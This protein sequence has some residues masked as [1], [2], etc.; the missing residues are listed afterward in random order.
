[1][2]CEVS[3]L[4]IYLTTLLGLITYQ[5]INIKINQWNEELDVEDD[6]TKEESISDEEAIEQ[7]Q[8]QI[9]QLKSEIK[10]ELKNEIKEELFNTITPKLFNTLTPELMQDLIPK[11]L[12]P[13]LVDMMMTSIHKIMDHNTNDIDFT[14]DDPTEAYQPNDD[15]N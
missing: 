3:Y 8:Q 10:E 14:Q 4:T 9:N 2:S 13:E 11:M 1:M 12:T 7:V 15:E 5:F 6:N